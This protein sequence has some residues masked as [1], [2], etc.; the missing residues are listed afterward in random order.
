MSLE[1]VRDFFARNA[2]DIEIIELDGSTATVELAALGHGVS[3]GQI[4]KTLS[5]KV[6]DRNFLLVTRGDARLDNKK[7]KAQFG[8]KVTML[9]PEEVLFVTGHAVGG[10]CP[11]GLASPLPVYCDISLKDFDE[12]VPAAGSTRSAVKI[13]PARMAELVGAQWIDVCKRPGEESAE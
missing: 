6:Q 2:P 13:A 1:T 7:A 5:L 4:A 11:F 3:P 12:V 10:V 9:G 8:G